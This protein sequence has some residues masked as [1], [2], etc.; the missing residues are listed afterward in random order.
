[1]QREADMFEKVSASFWDM[2]MHKEGCRV[3]QDFLE[4][5]TMGQA[6]SLLGNLRGKMLFAMQHR[7]ANYVQRVGTR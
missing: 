3:V 6:T 1:M 2:A 4:T 5:S 7:N